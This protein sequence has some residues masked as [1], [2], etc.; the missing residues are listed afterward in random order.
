MNDLGGATIWQILIGSSLAG[1]SSL[2]RMTTARAIN[3]KAD[4]ELLCL[5]FPP[6]A[7]VTT[8]YFTSSSDLSYE[9]LAKVLDLLKWVTVNWVAN[10]VWYGLES[11]LR[12]KSR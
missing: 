1:C 10:L 12:G 4:Y 2:F 5:V 3:A 9:H 8:E 6:L 11:A 7:S